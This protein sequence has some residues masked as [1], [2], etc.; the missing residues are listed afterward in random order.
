MPRR[1]AYQLPYK[2]ESLDI[3]TQQSPQP[4]P[5]FCFTASIPHDLIG[6][7]G[8]LGNRYVRGLFLQD[9]QYSRKASSSFGV[10]GSSRS[11]EPFPLRTWISMSA[12]PISLIFR[13]MSAMAM[14]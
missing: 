6:E 12:G 14:R 7:A 9:R 1:L 8:A 3:R 10:R 5:E 4:C 2:I 11:R 13:C